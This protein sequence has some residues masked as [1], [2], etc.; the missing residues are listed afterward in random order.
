M[1]R[2]LVLGATSAIAQGAARRWAEQGE[3]LY[4]VAR[5]A[6][7]LAVVAADLR[8]R[9]AGRVIERQCDLEA[10]DRAG[11]VIAAA[12]AELGGIDVVLMAWGILG[13]G[14]SLRRDPA[15][16]RRLLEIDFVHPAVWLDRVA[17]DLE[18]QRSGV[19]AAIGSVAGDRG[20]QSNYHYGSAKGGLAIFLSG[21]RN[22][23][24]RS[25]VTVLTVKP[26]FVD[27][28]M[29]AAFRKGPLWASPE[30]VGQGIVRAIDRRRELVYLPGYWR[31][32]LAG[33][34]AIPEWLFKRLRL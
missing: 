20:R 1:K 5:T 18:A 29:T 30:R 28:P 12:R 25:G 3:S 4:L 6:E 21:L 26:G 24:Y 27:T 13:D 7:K 2:I 9:G 34:R 23:L 33:I 11:E 17:E 8:T 15:G 16:C 32:I 10:S 14:E 31:V 22:R 19:L